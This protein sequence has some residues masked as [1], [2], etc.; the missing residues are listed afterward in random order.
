MCYRTVVSSAKFLEGLIKRFK[1]S[2]TETTQAG[3]MSF[4]PLRALA[5]VKTW[6]TTYEDDFIF[7]PAL[8][9]RTMY[10]STH[11]VKKIPPF[12]LSPVLIFFLGTFCI[13]WS[14]IGI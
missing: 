4:T 2:Q 12:A 3:G 14:E 13:L 10:V 5:L 8:S 7:N 6:I 11:L 1:T 9:S